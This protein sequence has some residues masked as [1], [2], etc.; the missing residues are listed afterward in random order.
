MKR[1]MTWSMKVLG[2]KKYSGT[3]LLAYLKLETLSIRTSTV[4]PSISINMTESYPS[5]SHNVPPKSRRKC[6]G[7]LKE[8]AS[9]VNVIMKDQQALTTFMDDH[10]V[11][12]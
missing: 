7:A 4:R 6:P 3:Y 10:P 9:R 12:W 1:P 5:L 2:L 11:P 8:A